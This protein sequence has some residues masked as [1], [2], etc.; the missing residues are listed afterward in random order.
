MRRARK[1][2]RQY[3]RLRG[4]DTP[5]FEQAI[6]SLEAA[7]LKFCNQFSDGKME[8]WKPSSIGMVPSIEADTRY[9]T[10]ATPGSTLTDIPFSENVD[11]QGVLAGMK[12][13]DFVHTADNEVVYLERILN[14]KA[15]EM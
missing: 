7:F 13:E 11:P 14:E 5:Q 12:G 2:I 1:Y 6:H 9:F 15:E 8:E 3:V 4:V 10:K